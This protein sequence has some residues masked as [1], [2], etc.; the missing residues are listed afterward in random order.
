[1]KDIVKTRALRKLK[2]VGD[3]AH[4]LQDAEWPSIPGAEL[5]FGAG[6]QRLGCA[7]EQP[8][9]N[10]VP[11]LELDVAVACIVVF[12]GQLLRL[13]QT[14][15]YL[16]QDLVPGAK[17]SIRGLCTSRARCIGQERRRGAA[18]DNLEWR[19]AKGGVE[20]RVVAILRP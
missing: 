16:R 2:T 17:K 11:H 6:H 13:E 5:P 14:L 15:A 19:G 18:V 3:V 9:P 10:P 8:Q 20:G 4:A 12:L 7:V 1:M